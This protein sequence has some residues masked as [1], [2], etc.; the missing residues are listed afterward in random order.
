MTVPVPENPGQR[1]AEERRALLFQALSIEMMRGS[2]LEAQFEFH[3]VMV[4]GRPVNNGLHALLSV[5]S[6][7]AW[8]PAWL[9]LYVLGGEKRYIVAVDESGTILRKG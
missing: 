2:R 9:A 3:A 5:F 8:A 1:P 6:C 4:A 7:G